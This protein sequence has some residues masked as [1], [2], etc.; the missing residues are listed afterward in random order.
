MAQGSFRG[1][2]EQNLDPLGSVSTASNVDRS[3][4][5]SHGYAGLVDAKRVSSLGNCTRWCS[6]CARCRFI[7]FNPTSNTCSWFHTYPLLQHGTHD[8]SLEQTT[9]GP[10]P[11]VAE[12]GRPRHEADACPINRWAEIGE[13]SF[14]PV[15]KAS[16]TYQCGHLLLRT[17][18]LPHLPRSCA[19]LPC[20]RRP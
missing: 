3:A 12:D 19:L 1:Y 4:S 10:L 8:S 6:S 18:A 20:V 11:K 15:A 9:V 13:R 14:D 5:C 17:A 16:S 2:C 7:S